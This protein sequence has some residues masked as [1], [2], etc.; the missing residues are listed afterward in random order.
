MNGKTVIAIT[1]F[2]NLFPRTYRIEDEKG[3]VLYEWQCPA[4]GDSIA[5]ARKH[6]QERLKEYRS[7]GYTVIEKSRNGD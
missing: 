4:F 5:I 1:V 3:E 6:F 2:T 7:K